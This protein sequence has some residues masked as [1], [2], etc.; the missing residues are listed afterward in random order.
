MAPDC[1][2]WRAALNRIVAWRFPTAQIAV[3]GRKRLSTRCTA[4]KSGSWKNRREPVLSWKK[5]EEYKQDIDI[6]RLA[7]EMVID[8]IVEPDE[9]RTELS[10]RFE[11]YASKQL[12]F[13]QRK[14]PVYPV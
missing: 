11:A 6:Y 1:M 8:G 13:S 5:R 7:G 14:H 10:R 9:L 2:P 4:T 12:Q 3:M